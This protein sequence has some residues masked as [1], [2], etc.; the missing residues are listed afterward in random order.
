M[1]ILALLQ[2]CVLFV[3]LFQWTPSFKEGGE[4]PLGWDLAHILRPHRPHYPEVGWLSFLCNSLGIW[5]LLGTQQL[6]TLVYLIN[7]QY[8]IN[9]QGRNFSKINKRTV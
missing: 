8:E 4:Y 9:A 5:I 7:A 6:G 1:K 2:I 3:C